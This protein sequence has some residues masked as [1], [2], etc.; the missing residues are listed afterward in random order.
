MRIIDNGE[1]KKIMT[2]ITV[3]TL[4][5]VDCLTATDCNAATRANYN[6]K[7]HIKAT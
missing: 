6:F 7:D 1:N 3:T 4:L 5:P 2:E